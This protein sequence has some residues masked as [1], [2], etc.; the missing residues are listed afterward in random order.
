MSRCE[1]PVAV[2][3][4][5]IAAVFLCALLL[6]PSPRRAEGAA[7]GAAAP[8]PP[9]ETYTYDIDFFFLKSVA[10]GT[11]RL[12]RVS[13]LGYRA[14]LVAET[15]GIIGFLTS[16][17]KNQYISE[18]DYDPGRGRFFA[19]RYTKAIHRGKNISKTTM[20]IDAE[21]RAV[22][23]ATFYNDKLREKGSEPIPSGVS[24]EDLLSAFFNFRR[25]ALG[26]LEK[27]SRFTIV[28]LPAY[29][30]PKG[31]REEGES[32]ARDFEVRVADPATELSY[33]KSYGRTGEPGLLVFVKVP[34][35]LFG[36]ETGEVR[37][38]FNPA[39]TPVSATVERAYYFG[40]VHGTLRKSEIGAPPRL[41]GDG[42]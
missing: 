30:I 28:T 2:L 19:R 21:S 40:D 29:D 33:R 5:R 32:L 14:E 23:W 6:L 16:Y 4:P 18:M 17:R 10:E 38:W 36:Q 8:L 3:L 37:V 27:G 24:Y 7:P 15:R 42:R 34:K 20:E 9:E 1:I 12:R 22:R 26:S 25:G 41:G 13:R 11:I 31:E 39:L 35:E